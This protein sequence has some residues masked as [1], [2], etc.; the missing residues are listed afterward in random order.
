MIKELHTFI[1]RWSLWKSLLTDSELYIAL[2]IGIGSFYIFQGNPDTICK[3]KLHF[4]DI[5]TLISIIFGFV[6]TTLVFYIQAAGS[7]R[8]SANIQNVAKLIVDWHIWTILCLFFL[9]LSILLTW[10]FFTSFSVQWR[11]RIFSFLIFQSFYAGFQILNHV[12]T[13][14]FVFQERASLIDSK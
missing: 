5:I 1:F 12:L 4:P 2:A 6:L 11:F 9:L 3:I 8:E 14:W 10:I 13:V 7:W